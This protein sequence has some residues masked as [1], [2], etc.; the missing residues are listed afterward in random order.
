[1]SGPRFSVVIPTC[2]RNDLLAKCLE[3]L[4][5]GRQLAE[6]D[7]EVVVSD[8]GSRETAEA[9]VREQ[10]PWARWTQGPRRGPAA[11]RNHGAAQTSGAW[12]AFTDD[13]C[14]PQEDWLKHMHAAT[15]CLDSHVFEG[16]TTTDLPLK[17]PLWQAPVNENGGFLWSCN[18]VVAREVF[19]R[20][21]GFDENFPFPHQEDVDLRIR[22]KALGEA[23]EFVPQAVIHHPQRPATSWLRRARSQQSGVYLCHKHGQPL[24]FANLDPVSFL[25]AYK[26]VITGP[27]PLWDKARFLGGMVA[28]QVYLLAKIPS[29]K[30]H[31]MNE[32]RGI[33]AKD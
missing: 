1:M 14:I 21:G 31:Y 13:D 18:L 19:D 28:E 30:K 27:G 20:L 2:H 24:S 29:W 4:V 32:V 10:F 26:R 6:G 22:L 15:V 16:K 5:P 25:R 11:N 7:Y 9:L 23:W 17:G 33:E 8:D 12:L 3:G